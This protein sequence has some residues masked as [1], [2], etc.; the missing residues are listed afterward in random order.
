MLS[1][2]KINVQ[3][4]EQVLA[5]KY[6][7]PMHSIGG[8]S[9]ALQY[10]IPSERLFFSENYAGI[11]DKPL[12][13]LDDTNRA[14]ALTRVY[15]PNTLIREIKH[16]LNESKS[17]FINIKLW[18]FTKTEEFKKL[19]EKKVVYETISENY[20]T[21]FQQQ[22]FSFWKKCETNGNNPI[23]KAL[24]KYI[25]EGDLPANT[26]LS[27]IGE[28]MRKLDIIELNS[29]LQ[30]IRVR[31]ETNSNDLKKLHKEQS[32]QLNKND[33]TISNTITAGIVSF[34]GSSIFIGPLYGMA[35][36]LIISCY[37][38]SFSSLYFDNQHT[39]L[40]EKINASENRLKDIA[41]TIEE[42]IKQKNSNDVKEFNRLG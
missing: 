26:Y 24:V 4:T 27:E 10:F 20:M 11:S 18:P 3:N 34:A 22:K 2:Q 42:I 35:L 37:S 29:I 40:N 21:I 1:H 25:L 16:V 19:F 31:L 39:Q 30:S 12:N 33:A 5:Y 41:S 36:S 23:Q 13:T 17:N 6:K 9:S 28:R 14:S 7:Q 32:D 38:Y 15:I 8:P